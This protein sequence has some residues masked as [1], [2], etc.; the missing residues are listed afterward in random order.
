[1]RTC[2]ECERPM[3]KRRGTMCSRCRARIARHGSASIVIPHKERNYPRGEAHHA[4]TGNSVSYDDMHRRVKR[5]RGSASG[6]PCVTCG[7]P[8]RHWSYDHEDP[9]ELTSEKGAYST[10]PQHYVPRCVPCHKRYDLAL[11]PMVTR[12]VDPETVRRLHAQ[13]VR[14]TPMAKQFG[15]STQRITRLL[16]ELGLPRFRPGSPGNVRARSA[17]ARVGGTS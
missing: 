11:K 3:G 10:E 12:P 13:G 14:V 15:V 1:M 5:A 4:W 17:D 2:S 6:Y 9:A 16:D 7:G 8:A